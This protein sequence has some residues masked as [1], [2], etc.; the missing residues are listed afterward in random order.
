MISEDDILLKKAQLER[1]YN[2]AREVLYNKIAAYYR[3]DISS[4]YISEEDIV[5]LIRQ[6]ARLKKQYVDVRNRLMNK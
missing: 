5:R 4:T 3:Q 1:D 6:C 2:R